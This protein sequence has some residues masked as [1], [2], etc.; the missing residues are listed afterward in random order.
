MEIKKKLTEDN[1]EYKYD[2]GIGLELNKEDYNM[3]LFTMGNRLM[4]SSIN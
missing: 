4:K 1:G 2:L 3:Y